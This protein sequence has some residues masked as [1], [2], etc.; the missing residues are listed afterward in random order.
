MSELGAEAVAENRPEPVLVRMLDGFLGGQFCQVELYVGRTIAPHVFR[1][2]VYKM[3]PGEYRAQV[4]FRPDYT[5]GPRLVGMD[6][7]LSDCARWLRVQGLPVLRVVG[8]PR[9]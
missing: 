1:W 6:G 5:A 9:M 2:G 4:L 8:L 7:S 3:R